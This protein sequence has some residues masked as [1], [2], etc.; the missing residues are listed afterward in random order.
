MTGVSHWRVTPAE[1]GQKLLQ[2]L[3]RR[4]HRDIPLSALHRW[5]RTGQVRVDGARAKPGTRLVSGQEIRIPPHQSPAK[6]VAESATELAVIEETDDLLIVCKPRGLPVHPGSGHD[7]SIAT[8]LKARF[9][10]S[11]WTPTPAHRL[12]RDTSGLLVTAKSYQAL[13]ELHDLWRAGR[14]HKAYL[15]WVH[16]RTPWE[17][18]TL[19][20]DAADKRRING[21]EKMVLGQGRQMHSQVMT[22]DWAQNSSLVLVA[23]LTGRTHQIRVQLSGQGHP[24]LGDAKYGGSVGQGRPEILLHAWYLAWPGITYTALPTWPRPWSVLELVHEQHLLC[25]TRQLFSPGQERRAP[26][27]ETSPKPLRP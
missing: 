19:I 3:A 10:A 21:R 27:S 4:F 18:P 14:V 26:C 2:F 23:P 17:M 5:I 16:G 25:M 7:D 22:I 6:A 1:A 24:L 11:A 9:A 8:R 15:A 13:R 20:T 12:D